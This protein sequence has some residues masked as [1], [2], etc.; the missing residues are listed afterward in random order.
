MP[1]P[2]GHGID[3]VSTAFLLDQAIAYP[4]GRTSPARTTTSLPTSPAIASTAQPSAAAISRSATSLARRRSGFTIFAT[5]P[6]RS[7]PASVT[8]SPSETSS[9]TPTSR[10]PSATSTPS[11]HPASQTP[12]P[13]PS[14]LPRRRIAAKSPER[15]FAPPS[16]NLARTNRGEFSTAPPSPVMTDSP[17]MKARDLLAVLMR[18]PLAYE[19]VRQRGSHRRLSAPGRPS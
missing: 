9:A 18:E 8:R 13:K 15:H 5:R 1:R 2:Y 7:S 19:I 3:P 14:R 16:S 10:P 17:S 4:A 11:A 12:P 6:E